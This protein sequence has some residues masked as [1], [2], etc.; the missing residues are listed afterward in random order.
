MMN[1]LTTLQGP[2]LTVDEA[3]IIFEDKLNPK[4]VVCSSINDFKTIV[5][6]LAYKLKK[7]IDFEL[8]IKLPTDII[9]T[10]KFGEVRPN[11]FV[12]GV[13][14]ELDNNTINLYWKWSNNVT[15]IFKSF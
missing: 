1:R 6:R 4:I 3:M 15:T 5:I 7:Y 12:K 2:L 9:F 13:M 14:I 11:E 8:P 10:D